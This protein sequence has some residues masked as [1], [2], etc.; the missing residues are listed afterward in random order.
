MYMAPEVV[1]GET[2]GRENAMDIWSLGC[3]ILECAK[4]TRP[5]HNLDNEWAI[6]FHI[7]M[8]KQTPALPDESQLS[9]LGIDFIRQ[10]LTI[11]PEKRPSAVELRQHAW[12]QAL[13]EELNAAN[14]EEEEAQRL[15]DEE[16]AAQEA[17]VDNSRLSVP[18]HGPRRSSFS[19]PSVPGVPDHSHP[20]HEALVADVQYRREGEQIKAMLEPDDGL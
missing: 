2:Q 12:I 10:C 13:V 20:R 17:L 1:K 3:V 8:A 6:M 15:K 19:L 14:E 5:W 16:E 9:P 4:G 11:D 7:G 18:S